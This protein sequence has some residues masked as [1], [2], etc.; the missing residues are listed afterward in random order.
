MGDPRMQSSSLDQP[1]HRPGGLAYA[2]TRRRAALHPP[3][4]VY[5]MPADVRKDEDV[6]VEMRDGVV[7]RLNLF[8]P[9][10]AGPFPVI[11][12]AH[13]YGKDEVPKKKGGGWSLN[14]QFRIMNQPTP[15]RIS[16]RTSWEAP[17]P[18]GWTHEGYA[19]INL[20][21][22]GG[23][24]SDGRGELLSDQKADD[25]CQVIAWAA[26][27]PRATGR[28]GM[29][30]VSYL[31]L[32]QYKVAALNPPALKAICPW[33]GFTDAY[34]DFFTPGGITENGFARVWLFLTSRLAR[35]KTNFA[36]ERR[37]H[38]LR[39]AWWEAI[40]PDV[41]RIRVPILEC[42]S[43]SDDNLHS[44]GSMRAFQHSGS[45]D[46]HAY[47]HRGPRWATFYG[48]EARQTQLAFFDRHLHDR[49]T[50]PLP[51]MR[52]EIRDR[53]DHIV[54]VRGER[55]RPLGRAA[56][57]QLHLPAGRSLSTHPG[58]A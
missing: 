8:R 49:D 54:E 14:K 22:R 5:P 36:A 42:T 3:V 52:L 12:S 30:G 7:L 47:A 13:P 45:N 56:R 23:G 34:R 10:G 19:V 31:A 28:V 9:T 16:D 17:D 55:E 20:D 21:T 1:W 43:F 48:E 57:R 33:E 6:E 53:R 58:G 29:L 39:D 41:S 24:H 51:P 50:A 25:V 11:L 40:T 46:R 2:R 26:D 4:T 27:Q 37:K 35:L 44:V 18:V 32:S 15:L 38:P